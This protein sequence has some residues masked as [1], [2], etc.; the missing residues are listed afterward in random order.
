MLSVINRIVGTATPLAV[1]GAGV[2]FACR[3][4][5]L[6]FTRP[7]VCAKALFYARGGE[8]SPLKSMTLA[9]A[10]TLGVGNIVGV[11][12]AIALGGFG[13]V[14]WMWISAV[15]AMFLKYAEI[16]LAMK[17]R[18]PL[19][20][21]GHRGGAPY[22]IRDRLSQ[23]A[24]PRVGTA[25]AI[26]FALLCVA[27]ALMMGCVIQANAVTT[28]MSATFSVPPAVCGILLGASCFFLSVG[29]RRAITA[30]TNLLVPF[31]SAVFL[32]ISLY[33]LVLRADA[34]PLAFG[35]IFAGAFQA[36]S[37]VGGVFGFLLSRGLRFGTIRGL[38]SNEAGCGTSPT[39]HAAS[40]AKSPVEQGL[41]GIVEVFV[42]TVLLCTVTA[43]VVIIHF[44]SVS[45]LARDPMTMT[46]AA[47]AAPFGAKG[48][49]VIKGLLSVSI[50][51]FGFA[52][53]LC[54]SHYGSES[55]GFILRALDRKKR[56]GGAR[57]SLLFH[58]GF[59]AAA[60]W[61]A[62]A[63]PSLIWSLT[64]LVTGI[65][66]LLNTSVLCLSYRQIRAETFSYFGRPPTGSHRP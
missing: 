4:R 2:Y 59:S 35:R 30:V 52:T 49:A 33:V 42:D 27:N 9:L 32:L 10:G 11:S 19:P 25:S 36:D 41:F 5:G 15:A 60:L 1:L 22:Y 57:P 50:L 54:W 17:H 37:A 3:M 6:P 47:Y 55:F 43:L 44:D 58:I 40:D 21:G 56:E 39:A 29:G 51:C 18:Q 24:S 61:G 38:I 64:D 20:K 8:R 7:R 26:L 31:M 23:L 12:S 66:T 14:F 34:V 62:A 13:A 65:M 45:H 53:M 46:L 48:G 63:A 28:S 16:V